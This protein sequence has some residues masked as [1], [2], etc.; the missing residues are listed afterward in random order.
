MEVKGNGVGLPDVLLK[1][2]DFEDVGGHVWLEVN[3]WS[4][5]RLSNIAAVT[6]LP[7]ASMADHH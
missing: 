7:P 5:G 3:G 2:R 4:M 1:A 6:F